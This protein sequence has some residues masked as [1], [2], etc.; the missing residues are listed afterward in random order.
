MTI[1]VS[2]DVL[3][4][5]AGGAGLR[6]AIAAAEQ[7]CRVGV[8]CKS[9][10]GKAHTVMA[11]GGIAAALGNLDEADSWQTHFGDTLRGGAMLN[12][13]RMVELYAHEVIDRVI[14]LE[15]WGGV[16][17]RT[18]EGRIS[19]RAFGA[20][21]WR[22]LAHI[23]DRT[24]LELIRTCQDR[25]IHTDG[26]T[27]HME[28]TLT[29]LLK[30][31]DR[32]AGAFGYDR[33]T[34][35][36]V[37]I[38]AKAV[39][40]AT[41][42]WGRMYLITSNSW[43]GTG[44]GAAM[45]YEAGAELKDM[46]FVQFH[47][48]GMVWPPG[49]RGILVT[50]AVRGEGGILRNRQGERFMSRYDP[51]KKDLSSRDV[52]ARSIFKEVQAGRGSPHGGVFLDVTH[53][54]A[55][56]IQRRLPSMY[57]QFHSLAGVDITK[58]PMEVAPTIHYTMGGVNVEAETAATTVTGLY[59][60]GEVAAGLHGANRLGG[61]SL[62]DILVFGRR[63]G[64]A[65]AD[66][67]RSRRSLPRVSQAAIAAEQKLLLGPLS[68]G[69]GED[70]FKLHRALQNAMQSGAAIA[71]T[72]ESLRDTLEEILELKERAKRIRVPGTAAYNPAFSE[73]RDDL[74]MLT[75]SEA[76]VRSGIERRE[77]RGSQWRLDYPDRDPELGKVNLVA[78]QD[79]AGR[80]AVTRAPLVP[81]PEHL[82]KLAEGETRVA[83]TAIA[84]AAEAKL[85]ARLKGDA[86]PAMEASADDERPTQLRISYEDGATSRAVR[87]KVWRGNA[88][89]GDFQDF[90]VPQIEGMVVLDAIHWLQANG[91][92]DLACRW[93]CKA[94]KCG[95]C[96]AEVN[97][98]PVLLCKT[99]VDQVLQ[100]AA[101]ISVRPM[102][103]FPTIEDLVTDVSWN[104][105]VNRRIQ[106]FTPAPG[107]HAP[108]VI[109]PQD[110][111]RVSEQRR[112]IEC[113]LCQDVCHVLR[114]HDGSQR[115]YGPRF[116]VRLASL[117]MHPKDVANRIPQL[118]AEAGV[119]LCNIT[120]CCTEVCPEHIKITDNSIIPL[121][122]RVA[123]RYLDPLRGA[124]FQLRSRRAPAAKGGPAEGVEPPPG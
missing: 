52:V 105:E 5:G 108:F 65:A 53:L 123:D 117:E 73:A 3:V 94:G 115:F 50:E 69:Q 91:A 28:T 56:T 85:Q 15:E 16:F 13:W 14:E 75:I 84:D 90:S 98:R 26:V 89:G 54:G 83:A 113:F 43:E 96:S 95:S 112:C 6:A 103:V 86:L 51:I 8:V 42:G 9:L 107:D 12:N 32:I 77:S 58:E 33:A 10:L 35:E 30:D 118:H 11:E 93:N 100:S 74:F 82:R 70:P 4:L 67:A 34:G 22:R 111:E 104:Y 114:E 116:L 72:E 57:E 64:E 44:D 78:R 25:L 110:I 23:G 19:Q 61:N 119:A 37:L 106:P 2:Y 20:H 81:M 99:R 18:K 59:A 45:A 55:E 92:G 41:G 62:G 121:K 46:E 29:R 66:Y 87:L 24:G 60:A 48:T 36:F 109:Y 120:K 7:G 40:L 80:M 71:R 79:G 31:G 68:G 88:Q 101:E 124:L 21:S 97:G 1:E 122:E 49:A 27:V 47:P 102:R 76:I 39:V 17:D 38:R 63:A